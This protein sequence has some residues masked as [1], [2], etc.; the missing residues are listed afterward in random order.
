MSKYQ[1]P[2]TIEDLK[3]TFKQV[4]ASR[5]G[6]RL[7]IEVD[8]VEKVIVYEVVYKK[9]EIVETSHYWNLTEALDKFNSY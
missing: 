9:D 4:W 1:A 6:A 3:G 8:P 7:W 5:N 2:V